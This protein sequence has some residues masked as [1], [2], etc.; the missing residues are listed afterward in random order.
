AREDYDATFRRAVDSGA[1]M[2]TNSGDPYIYLYFTSRAFRVGQ[3]DFTYGAGRMLYRELLRQAI[4]DGHDGWMED[5]G[6]YTPLDAHDAPGE[7][8]CAVHN[9]DPTHYHCPAGRGA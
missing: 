2:K 6:E 1:L 8:G 3:F 4:A 7:T 9:R 5:F